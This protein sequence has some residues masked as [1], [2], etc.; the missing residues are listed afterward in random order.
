[1][2]TPRTRIHPYAEK[3]IES[4]EYFPLWYLTREA[5]IESKKHLLTTLTTDRL[6]LTVENKQTTYLTTILPKP[7]RMQYLMHN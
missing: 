2:G 5:A 7:Q 1:M 4:R 6:E 3:Y